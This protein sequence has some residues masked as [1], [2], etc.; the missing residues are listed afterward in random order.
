MGH[1]PVA[2]G[3]VGPDASTM[4]PAPGPRGYRQRFDLLFAL[5]LIVAKPGEK[6][7]S[8]NGRITK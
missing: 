3:V 8:Q 6:L 5:T 7:Q 4:V 1:A 2:G